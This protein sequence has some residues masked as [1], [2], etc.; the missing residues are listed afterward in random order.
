MLEEWNDV[1]RKLLGTYLLIAPSYT[2]RD[3]LVM[4][5]RRAIPHNHWAL[6]ERS[7]ERW[8]VRVTPCLPNFQHSIISGKIHTR[9]RLEAQLLVGAVTRAEKRALFV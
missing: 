3:A 1:C 5:S 6:G 9:V 4:A 7:A 2:D 8:L